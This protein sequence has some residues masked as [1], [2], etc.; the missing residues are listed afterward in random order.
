MEFHFGIP[1]KKKKKS[2]ETKEKKETTSLKILNKNV[3]NRISEYVL[4]VNHLY[5]STQGYLRKFNIYLC[6]IF[7]QNFCFYRSFGSLG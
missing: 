2:Q 1:L 7:S 3:I 5:L 4:I 6:Y